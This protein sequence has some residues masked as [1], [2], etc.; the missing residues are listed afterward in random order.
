MTDSR[1]DVASISIVIPCYNRAGL[2][3][4]AIESALAYGEGAEVIVVDDGSTDASWEVISS[5]DDRVRRFR[6]PNGGVSAARNFGVAQATSAFIRFLDSD[7]RMAPQ[8]VSALVAAQKTA[9]SN[10][11]VF[12]DASAIGPDG[13]ALSQC[14]YG[15]A[16]VARPGLISRATLLSRIMSPLLPLYPR[17]ALQRLGGFDPAFTL[18]EDQEL[19]VRLVAAGYEFH[20]VPVIVAEVREHGGARLSRTITAVWYDRQVDV[21][22]AIVRHMETA[23]PPITPHEASA[24]ATMLWV[25]A[26]DAARARYRPQAEC[27]F[28]F[29]TKL[30]GLAAAPPRLRPLYRWVGLYRTERIIEVGKRVLRGV[31]RPAA[32]EE[33]GTIDSDLAA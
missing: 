2:V 14:G 12:G 23:T 29:A 19:A 32:G 15:Y 7:D 20:R 17:D 4:Q 33:L 8:G 9:P 31:R 16:A 11:I 18:G 22:S 25:V 3:G 21:F 1:D 30:V 28:A 5:F 26:R 6:I 24:L 27:L 13:K 10:A